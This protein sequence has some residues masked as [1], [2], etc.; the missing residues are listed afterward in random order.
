MKRPILN[1]SQRY[2][3]QFNCTQTAFIKLHIEMLKVKREIERS[4]KRM[5]K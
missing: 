2:E 1:E 3:M 4:I 5:F